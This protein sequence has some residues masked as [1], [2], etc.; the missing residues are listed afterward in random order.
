MLSR[1]VREDGRRDAWRLQERG[2][3]LPV[4]ALRFSA[5][6]AVEGQVPQV[7]R[8]PI[9]G[10]DEVQVQAEDGTFLYVEGWSQD[11]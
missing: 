8:L 4:S 10:L 2:R 6:R 5:S 9:A 3:G 7:S 11:V 1:K